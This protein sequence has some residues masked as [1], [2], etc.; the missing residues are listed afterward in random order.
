M[1]KLQIVKSYFQ[2]AVIAFFIIAFVIAVIC[3]V[4]VYNFGATEE[5]VAS[6]RVTVGFFM[7]AAIGGGISIGIIQLIQKSETK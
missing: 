4:R 1:S 7:G 3:Q 6:L 2:L 5:A